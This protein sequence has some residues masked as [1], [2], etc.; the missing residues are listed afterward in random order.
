[1]LEISAGVVEE[2]EKKNQLYDENGAQRGME[3]WRA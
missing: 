1:M 2:I 3:F